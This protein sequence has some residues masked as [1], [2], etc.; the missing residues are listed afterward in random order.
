MLQLRTLTIWVFGAWQPILKRLTDEAQ[1]K[2]PKPHSYNKEV[3]YYREEHGEKTPEKE[4]LLVDGIETLEAT[5][6]LACE[7]LYR[8]L[9]DNTLNSETAIKM[10]NCFNQLEALMPKVHESLQEILLRRDYIMYT[11]RMC[12]GQPRLL[13]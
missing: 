9:S 5:D 11:C 10:I 2:Q 6:A 13:R 7:R 3:Y 8:T 4:T 12:P 1:G